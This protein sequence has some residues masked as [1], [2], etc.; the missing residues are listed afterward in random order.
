MIMIFFLSEMI[1][2]WSGWRMTAWKNVIF[3]WNNGPRINFIFQMIHFVTNEKFALSW[4]KIKLTSRKVKGKV[5]TTFA[6]LLHCST[7]SSLHCDQIQENLRPKKKN[8]TSYT[9]FILSCCLKLLKVQL[10]PY[11]MAKI[12]ISHFLNFQNLI[13]AK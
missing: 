10:W 2:D 6:I 11:L 13:L 5:L 8:K 4:P 9:F 3:V 12:S 7:K 1:N